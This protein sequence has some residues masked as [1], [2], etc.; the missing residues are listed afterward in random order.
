MLVKFSTVPE[1][2]VPAATS[3]RRETTSPLSSVPRVLENGVAAVVVRTMLW[4]E[5]KLAPTY[6]SI[7]RGPVPEPEA[8]PA[9]TA[10]WML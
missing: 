5:T 6:Q 4:P 10:F 1:R 2:T 7:S 3:A 8:V 9:T